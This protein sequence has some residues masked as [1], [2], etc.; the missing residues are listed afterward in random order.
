MGGRQCKGSARVLCSCLT[1]S[2]PAP[3]SLSQ[4][5]WHVSASWHI[6]LGP[7]L[8]PRV[9][10]WS[11]VDVLR[12]LTGPQGIVCDRV[13]C[14]SS[15]ARYKE[16]GGA[17]WIAARPNNGQACYIV[18]IYLRIYS[19]VADPSPTLLPTCILTSLASR[20]RCPVSCM[21]CMGYVFSETHTEERSNVD[22]YHVKTE[23]SYGG[24]VA[25]QRTRSSMNLLFSSG[26]NGSSI[27]TQM[28]LVPPAGLA[29]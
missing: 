15:P 9:A 10:R 4:H 24:E 16:R 19:G 26:V 21:Q 22:W 3:C 14:R 8:V 27:L 28:E 29:S 7:W 5:Q 13:G 17:L 2:G 12:S 1:E 20:S 18:P 25:Q 23:Y 11:W 6:L